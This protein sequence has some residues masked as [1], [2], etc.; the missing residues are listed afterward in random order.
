VNL[1]SEIEYF[2]ELSLLDKAR[3]LNLFLH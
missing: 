1:Q 2:T 3:L